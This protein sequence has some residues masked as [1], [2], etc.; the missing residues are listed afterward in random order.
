MR[1]LSDNEFIALMDG[2]YPPEEFEQLEAYLKIATKRLLK[3]FPDYR[4][5]RLIASNFSMVLWEAEGRLNRLQREREKSW[6]KPFS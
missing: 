6:P 5:Q 4:R 2:H 1:M 3:R